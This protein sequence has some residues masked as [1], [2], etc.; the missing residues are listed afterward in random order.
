MP[1]YLMVKDEADEVVHHH[2]VHHHHHGE[3]KDVTDSK[4]G[5]AIAEVMEE[6]ADHPKEWAAYGTSLPG[7]MQIVGLEYAQLQAAKND[8]DHR[9]IKEELEDLAAACIH[10]HKHM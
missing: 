4:Y 3:A 2:H 1:K 9:Q 5:V 7:L 10:A 6:L 8:S